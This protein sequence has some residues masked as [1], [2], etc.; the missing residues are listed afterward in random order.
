MTNQFVFQYVNV[1]PAEIIAKA[2]DVL[3][4]EADPLRAGNPNSAITAAE[5][6]TLQGQWTKVMGY[7]DICVT[8]DVRP[9]WNPAWTSNGTDTGTPVAGVAPDWLVNSV[10]YDF[11]GDGIPDAKI[12]DF[13]SAAWQQIVINQVLDLQARG[14]DGVFLDD[15]GAYFS[16]AGGRT[17]AQNAAEMVDFIQ[18]IRALVGSTFKIYVNGSPYLGSDAGD[19][20]GLGNAIDGMILENYGRLTDTATQDL[21]LNAAMTNVAPYAELLTVDIIS[22]PAAYFDYLMKVEGLGLAS[23]A[24]YSDYSLADIPA[25]TGNSQANVILGSLAGNSLSGFG[26]DDKMA[27]R[28]GNDTLNGG[29]GN[30]VL[31]GNF[32]DDALLGSTGNDT[33]L[34]DL[35]ADT[36]TGGAGADIF[37]G[38]KGNDTMRSLADGTQ[39]TFIFNDGDGRDRVSGY[40]QGEDRLQLDDAL[41]LAA[42]PSGLTGQQVIDLYGKLNAAGTVLTLNFGGGD[43]LQVINTGGVDKATLGGDVLIV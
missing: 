33:M 29:S 13:A 17:P 35:G 39:D 20:V 6:A 1:D 5:L 9:W 42:H 31:M 18:S 30:D 8:D 12:V 4:T 15:V 24:T 40:V 23:Y 19:V 34:G 43:I 10:P 28:G 32:G 2:V 25:G 37:H 38:G 3:F 22:T 36:L 7:V 41:W 16:T 26:G 14:F 11:S 27:G 21:Y